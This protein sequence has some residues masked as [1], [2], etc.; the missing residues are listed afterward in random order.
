MK[1]ITPICINAENTLRDAMVCIDKNMKGIALVV[2]E[3]GKLRYTIT[4]GD[5]RRAILHGLSLDMKVKEWA[6]KQCEHG[7]KNPVTAMKSTLSQDLLQLMSDNDLKHIP[8]TDASGRVVDLVV[9]SDLIKEERSP[10][11]AVIMA[12]GSGRRLHPLTLDLPKPMLPVG[13]RPLLEHIVERLRMS[14]IHQVK[15]TT[16]Y[17]K[18]QI[19]RHFGN[20]EDFG[21]NIEYVEENSPLGTAGALGNFKEIGET[22]LVINGDILTNL[23]FRSMNDF[24]Y[25]HG[26]D[27]TVAVKQYELNV[28][29]GVI[30]TNGS[31]VTGV[32]EKPVVQHF[33]NAGIY[34][35]NQ[36]VCRFIPSD[37]PYE[38][39][40]LIDRALS[41]GCR[42]ASFP[43]REYW[44][45]IGHADDYQRAISD[46]MNGK[47]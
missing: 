16:R 17:K 13:D 42:V 41:E 14:G 15:M 36:K 4:D 45:D 5:V 24:H 23:D 8:L 18:D 12:G 31:F 43:I 27:M 20:G 7:N 30:E 6:E 25:E 40:D 19:T 2:D 34:L 9:V 28:P 22:L 1:D 39:T 29:Y 46:K 26:A 32:F 3:E 35:L 44:L 33:I 10:M 37:Q 21:V 47:I 11:T 38:M